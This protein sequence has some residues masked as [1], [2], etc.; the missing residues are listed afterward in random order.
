MALGALAA[1][2][3]TSL[4]SVQTIS[5]T[6]NK[7][8][9]AETIEKTVN[10]AKGKALPQVDSRALESAVEEIPGIEEARISGE[11]PHG[12]RV[13]VVERSPVAQIQR[14]KGVDL[15]DSQG[16]TITTVASADTHRLP[17]VSESTSRNQAAFT[18]LTAALSNIPDGV[19]ADMR[20]ATASSPDSVELTMN[21][22]VT[23]IWGNQD[24]S[25][26]KAAVLQ[27]LLKGLS[28]VPTTSPNANVAAQTTVIDVSVPERPV[29]R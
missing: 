21:S 26:Q 2:N 20:E 5:V 25:A 1:A 14:G 3:F 16:K 9:S 11:P 8:V 6:G 24:N 4:M 23:V 28:S 7:F 18:A 13:T 27:A 15:I 10:P 12:L 22:G 17:L 19:L 29:T